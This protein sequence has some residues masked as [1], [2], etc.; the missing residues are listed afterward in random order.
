MDTH[1]TPSAVAASLVAASHDLRPKLIAD[2]AAGNG[3][4]LL[5]A[6]RAWPTAKF[7]ATDIDHGAIR[8]L[9]RLRPSWTVGRCDLRSPRS[10]GSCHAL[11]KIL[12]S[13]TLL[14]LNPPFTCRGGT[15]FLVPTPTGPLSASTAMSFILIAT[16]YLAHA[17]HIVCVLPL[18]CL[19]SEKDA[20]AWNCLKSRFTVDV[21]AN[22]P[23]GTFPQTAA[24]T[25]LVHLSPS[26]SQ[27]ATI[28]PPS[29]TT[30]NTTPR[31]HVRL[32]RGCCPMHRLRHETTK[33]PLVHYTDIR[34]GT[35]ELNGRHGF[36]EFR[37]VD[38]PAVLIP[39][40]GQITTAKVAILDTQLSV[41][42]SDCVIAL[43]PLRPENVEPLRHR[44][45]TNFACLQSQY[46]GTGAPFITLDRLHQLLGTIGVQVEK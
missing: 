41:M 40:V 6:E 7:V 42:L 45:V 1:Y 15:R 19:H 17:G 20:Q 2:L 29:R 46:V 24:N 8:R 16:N 14:L 30:L 37:C 43:K 25:V 36:G 32:V 5:P 21:L 23:T 13:A 26:P 18:G 9:A 3:E 27:E 11:K 22:C 44:L 31:L 10:R 38:G 4:L 35:V 33:P 34:N 12:N 39:R 28:P